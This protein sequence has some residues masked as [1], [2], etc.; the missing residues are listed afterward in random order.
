M[1]ISNL[2]KT[3]YEDL[4]KSLKE[5]FNQSK[6]ENDE[7]CKEYESTIQLLTESFMKKKK[8]NFKIK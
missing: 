3:N 2:D 6:E 8:R 5:E 1:S 4:Y 7:L